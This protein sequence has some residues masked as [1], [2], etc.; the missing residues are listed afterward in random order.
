MIGLTINS[1]GICVQLHSNAFETRKNR[2]GNNFSKICWCT[3]QSKRKVHTTIET[4]L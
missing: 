1:N 2:R 4:L 3:F